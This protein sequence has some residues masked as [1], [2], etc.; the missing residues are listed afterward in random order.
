MD[1]VDVVF[2]HG[3][4]SSPRAWE[5][6]AELLAGD[7]DLPALRTHFFPYDSRVVRLRP[8]RRIPHLND[9]ADRLRTYLRDDVGT[10]TRIVLVS[11]SQG[12]LV[13][14]RFLARTLTR[15]AGYELAPIRRV[16]MFA[17]PNSGAEFARSLRR[18][19][20]PWRNPQ[21][22]ELR[23]LQETIIETHRALDRG[24]LNAHAYGP[25]EWPLHIAAYAGITDNIVPPINANGLFRAG[26]VVDGDH[27]SVIRPKTRADS[28]YLALRNEIVS[29]ATDPGP[30]S[31]THLTL[32]TILRV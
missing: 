4:F 16:V 13:I 21:E 26:G 25:N 5:P 27:F 30:V 22:R 31:Y 20:I 1:P 10:A 32:P 18:L 6:M 11:H 24:I 17:C 29:A 15:A 3:L 28:S 7:P 19:A 23:P 8:D 14:Q 9:I 12:G 2:V